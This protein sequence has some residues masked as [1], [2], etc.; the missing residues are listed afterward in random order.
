MALGTREIPDSQGPEWESYRKEAYFLICII[1]L[2][3]AFLPWNAYLWHQIGRRKIVERALSDQLEFMR[4]LIDDTPH[5]IYVRDINAR[6]ISCNRSYLAVFDATLAQMLGKTLVESGVFDAATADQFQKKFGGALVHGSPVIS[7]GEFI[8]N[9]RSYTIS[10][11]HC[12]YRDS[13]GNVMGII[14]G[15]VDITELHLAKEQADEASRAKSTFLATM[16]HEIRTPMSAI[17]GML[18]LILKRSEQGHW[19]RSSIEVAYDSAQTLLELI[20]GILDIAKIESGKFELALHRA[21]LRQL[22][23]S[24]TRLFDG[25]ARQKGLRLRVFID[26]EIVRDVLI[27]SVRFNQVL[28]NLISNAIKFTSKGQVT[29]KLSGAIESDNKSKELLH[30]TLSVEDTGQ[31]I[32]LADQRKLFAPFSQ[33]HTAENNQNGGTGLGLMISRKLVEL[34]GGTLL[35]KS[36]V[37]LGTEIHVNLT[38]LT[39]ESITEKIIEVAPQNVSEQLAL[40]VLVVDDNRPNRLVLRQQL[41]FLGHLVSEAENGEEALLRWNSETFDLII[42]DCNM[43]VMN[44][45]L[46]AQ[47]I[48][49]REQEQG[50]IPCLIVGLTAN[51]LPEELQHCQDAGMN[52]CLFKPILLH[53]LHRCL[54][55][56]QAL[57]KNAGMPPDKERVSALPQ[58]HTEISFDPDALNTLTGGDQQLV[59]SLMAELRISNRNDMLAIADALRIGNWQRISEL[60]HKVRGT[61]TLIRAD[62]LSR[63]C[64]DLELCHIP[65]VE[66]KQI[67]E[68]VAA[69]S[70]EVLRVDAYLSSASR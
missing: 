41:I 3:L 11:W 64:L 63:L 43:P 29:I 23:E 66:G 54:I 6:L 27:D 51:A 21:D 17:I 61:A 1:L 24:V 46:L 48:R 36:E 50:L 12:P 68:K 34:M 20:G 56:S 38:L 60:A 45:Y 8:V 10:Y 18:E 28:S 26:P 32:S 40:R 44:G 53:D 55:K 19:E 67:G 37:N 7:E 31:G 22:V 57:A 33:I 59:K 35:L 30:V 70:C 9:G 25:L 47:Q 69:L 5:P 2:L 58:N 16:S 62:V 4:V 39:L 14:G 65:P 15:W 42:T 49:Q 52:D 13:L